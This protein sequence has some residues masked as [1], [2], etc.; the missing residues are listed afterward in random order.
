LNVPAILALVALTLVTDPGGDAFGD[1]TLTPPTAPI[2]ANVA[3]FDLQSVALDEA[4]QGTRLAVTLGSLGLPPDMVAPGDAYAP[5]LSGTGEAPSDEA[6]PPEASAGQEDGEETPLKAF[7]PAVVDVYLGGAKGGSNRT[8]PGPDLDFPDGTGWE[9]ALRITSA[10]AFYVTYPTAGDEQPEEPVDV[11][12]LPR[13]PLDVFTTGNTLVVYLPVTLSADTLV[14]A[15]TG[16]YDP[17]SAS[18]WRSLSETPSPWQYS[19]ATSQQSPVVDLIAR[20]ADA[21]RDALRSGVLPRAGNQPSV[22]EVPWLW[23]MLAGLL[24]AVTGLIM[25]VRV[26]KPAPAVAEGPLDTGEARAP[27]ASVPTEPEDAEGAVA[28]ETPGPTEPEGAEDV[29][30]PDSAPPSEPEEAQVVLEAPTGVEDEAEDQEAPGQDG[31]DYIA[32]MLETEDGATEPGAAAP[33]VAAGAPRTGV[34]DDPTVGV[35]QDEPA[36]A[37]APDA[38]PAG[39]APDEP[40]SGAVPDAPPAVEAP[41]EPASGMAPDEPAAVVAPEAL[42]EPRDAS[43][44]A[45]PFGT[46]VEESFLLSLDDPRAITDLLSEDD[47]EENFWHPRA[48]KVQAGAADARD[49]ASPAG[50]LGAAEPDEDTDAG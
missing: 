5:A 40:A 42:G 24:V 38:P 27:E 9:Y 37:V 20:N 18:G 39:V 22:L 8:L 43:S 30:T 16:V 28:A 32:S 3:V 7:L 29:R 33:D 47:A 2:Y 35:G 44:G 31:D 10:G 13:R 50:G 17:F 19:G 15:M 21:Q 23:V 41:N 46:Q 12:S 26:R 4:E 1:G 34:D 49:A 14:H 25:R 11:L 48:R 36:A 6:G 45:D